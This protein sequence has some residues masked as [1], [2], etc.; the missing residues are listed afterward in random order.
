MGEL[1]GKEFKELPG[2]VFI[3]QSNQAAHYKNNRMYEM[4]ATWGMFFIYL[5]HCLTPCCEAGAGGAEIIWD[6][7]PKL[8]FWIWIWI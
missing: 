1:E 3:F 4:D 5:N 2:L 8:N 7:E 6:L